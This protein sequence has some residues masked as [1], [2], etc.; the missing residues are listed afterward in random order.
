MKPPIKLHKCVDCV[1]WEPA[2]TYF[3]AATG[4]GGCRFTLAR[5]RKGDKPRE[6]ATYREGKKMESR[7]TSDLRDG[8]LHYVKDACFSHQACP[9]DATGE[10]Y[11]YTGCQ[12]W[13]CGHI[14]SATDKIVALI[15]TE[16]GTKHPEELNVQRI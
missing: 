16:M 12:R 1:F 10:E 6:C 7:T 9:L 13:T 8:I 4:Q 14:L 5:N 3:G 15:E 2:L 11:S